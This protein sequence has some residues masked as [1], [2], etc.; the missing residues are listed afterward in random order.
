MI[1]EAG[2]VVRS[3]PE[4]QLLH[5]V[6]HIVTHRGDNQSPSVFAQNQPTYDFWGPIVFEERRIA[7]QMNDLDQVPSAYRMRILESEASNLLG[8]HLGD[9]YSNGQSIT[10]SR[11]G[12]EEDNFLTMEPR[13]QNAGPSDDLIIGMDG[14]DEIHGARGNDHL[15]GDFTTSAL[16]GD[17]DKLYGGDGHDRMY[18]GPGDD[19]FYG[20]KGDD[21]IWGG[22]ASGSPGTSDGTDRADYSDVTELGIFVAFGS[23]GDTSL[24][25]SDGQ[26]G[27]DTLHSIERILGSSKDNS[28]VFV[29]EG[30]DATVDMTDVDNDGYALTKQ[31]GVEVRVKGI[32]TFVGGDNLTTFIGNGDVGRA[33]IFIAGSGG[34]DFTLKSGNRAYGYDEVVDTFRVTTTVPAEFAAYTDAQKVEYLRNNRIFIGNFGE[35]DQIYVDGV[36]FNGNRVT[37]QFAP[38]LPVEPNNNSHTTSVWLTGDSSFNTAYPH[39]HHEVRDVNE[40]QLR[41]RTERDVSK[42][43]LPARR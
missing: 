35:E 8:W 24:T 41:V 10:F 3:K 13:D 26:L 19:A 28:F 43:L 20:G 5:E 23:D 7:P 6:L 36:L 1:N 11:R 9:N 29:G 16:G 15:Y 30:N 2:N 39:A 14:K 42:R 37:S 32:E 31:D 18:G 21:T 17:N 33:T 4:Y 40:F 34:G 12:D 27:L 22:Q 25:V 38:T